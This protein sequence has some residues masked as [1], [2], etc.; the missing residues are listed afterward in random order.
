MP[1]HP[2]L[3]SCVLKTDAIFRVTAMNGA[4]FWPRA[5]W[6]RDGETF[7][8]AR[9]VTLRMAIC[10]LWM[11]LGIIQETFEYYWTYVTPSLKKKVVKIL[12]VMEK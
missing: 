9:T 4:C 10:L 1:W 6:P 2:W 7:S 11:W 12:R 8:S 3:H 5:T